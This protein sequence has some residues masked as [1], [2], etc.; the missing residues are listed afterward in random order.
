M[1]KLNQEVLDVSM[2]HIQFEHNVCY[3]FIYQVRIYS[4]GD[5]VKRRI[6]ISDRSVRRRTN[7]LESPINA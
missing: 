5:I 1:L 3:F 2:G 6:E 7:N 4:R